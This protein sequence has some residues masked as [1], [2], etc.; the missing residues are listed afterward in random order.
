M[1]IKTLLKEE[2][3]LTDMRDIHIQLIEKGKTLLVDIRGYVRTSNY[4]GYT[5]KGITFR[6]D[7]LPLF[8]NKLR[9]FMEKVRDT[10]GDKD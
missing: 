7:K 10:Y 2:I 3:N 9:E 1:G 5:N 8:M 6:L 4:T